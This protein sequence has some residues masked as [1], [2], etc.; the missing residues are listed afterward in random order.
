MFSGNFGYA[1]T[2]II[3]SYYVFRDTVLHQFM[4]IQYSYNFS[5]TTIISGNFGYADTMIIMSYYVF[6]E[7]W[8]C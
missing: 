1:D 3:M 6:R 8:L 5:V 7:L 4:L 2:M